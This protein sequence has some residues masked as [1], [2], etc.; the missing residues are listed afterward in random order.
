M[1]EWFKSAFGRDY[2]ELYAHRDE[3]EATDLADL[4]WRELQLPDG[5]RIFD[6]P[7]GSG[8]H[9]R[10]FAARGGSVTGL[11]LSLDLLEE[12]AKLSAQ[13]GISYVRGDIRHLP[14]RPGSFNLLT[15]LFSSFGYFE[16]EEANE[17]ALRGMGELLAQGGW[18]VM[19]FLNAELVSQGLQPQTTRVMPDGRQVLEQRWIEELPHR[20]VNKRMLLLETTGE[21]REYLESVRLYT[22]DE[23]EDLLQRCG[24]SVEK[25][26]GT[27]RGAEIA[28]D[29]PRVILFSR[30]R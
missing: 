24:L 13:P 15:N 23:L 5:V 1:S 29:S 21:T 12:A 3:Q 25:R 16:Q 11:D 26:F 22:R 14:F 4:L 9:A 7:C 8:R 30:K 28:P 20:R 2:M 17:S 10:A 18:L 19:D 6:C 27:Y